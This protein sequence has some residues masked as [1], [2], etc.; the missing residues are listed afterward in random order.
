M[1]LDPDIFDK[2]SC[3][4]I[5]NNQTVLLLIAIGVL[6]AVLFVI[7]SNE[8]FGSEI[9]YVPLQQHLMTAESSVNC[10][11]TPNAPACKPTPSVNPV[12]TSLD[13]CEPTDG[14]WSIPGTQGGRSKLNT[15]CCQPPDYKL[16]KTASVFGQSVQ[17]KTCDDNLD[18]NNAI[19]KCVANCCSDANSEANNYDA[20]WYPMARCACSLWC[21]NQNVPHFKKYGTA[22][23]YITGDIAE[24][25]TSDSGAFIGGSGY[26]FSGN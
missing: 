14:Q 2:F 10:Q 5:M 22:V 15:P 7:P 4:Q 21:Y 3:I 1:I 19:E 24:A 6:I 11:Q 12:S 18:M 26:D 16:A 8:S 17:Y 9:P 25:Q 20:S 23:H 13:T